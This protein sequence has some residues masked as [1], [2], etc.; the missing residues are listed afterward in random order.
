MTS[1][2]TPLRDTRELHIVADGLD[3]AESVAWHS[4]HLWAGTEAGQLVRIDIDTGTWEIAAETGGCLLGLA[5]DSA[6]RCYACDS[7][8][9]RVLR[10]TPGGE[11]EIYA[12]AVRG[13]RLVT[14]NYAAFSSDGML[15]V[16]DSGRMGADDGY[17]I[18]I[19]PGGEPELASNACRRFPNGIA[20]GPDERVLY[21]VESRSGHVLSFARD[22]SNLS[23]PCSLATLPST[24]PDGVV[25]DAAGSVYVTCFQ[26]NRVYLLE[27]GEPAQVFLDD[28]SGLCL[29]APTNGCFGGERLATLFLTSLG[30]HT[31]SAIKVPVPG[32]GLPLPDV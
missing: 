3:H 22:G 18:Q 29:L 1:G 7:A 20:F 27:P 15:W 17:L 21:L 12:E 5:F 6:G 4:G 26:P 31:I 2:N 23:Q 14:P 25:V 32:A 9:G 13:R 19:P 10:I 16:T 28:W 30:W 8:R 11:V 24:V